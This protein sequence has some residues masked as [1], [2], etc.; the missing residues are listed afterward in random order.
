MSRGPIAW[1]SKKQGTIALSTLEAEYAAVSHTVWHILWHNMFMMELGFEA[2][3]Q[4]RLN[5]DNRGTIALSCDPQF[6][7]CSKH[8]DIHHHFIRDHIEH[9][10]I[11]ILHIR[12]EDNSADIFTKPLPNPVFTK[13]VSSLTDD[14]MT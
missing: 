9:G 4:S 13:F 2:P 1:T 10:N 7:G 8:I 14:I 12:S 5:N 11:S 3:R 6:H